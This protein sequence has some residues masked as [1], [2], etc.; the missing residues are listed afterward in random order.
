MLLAIDVGNTQTVFGL[1]R[2]EELAE[3]RR[4][5]T[6]AQR[7]GDE[8]SVLLRGLLGGVELSGIC[9]SSTVP[10]LVREYEALAER[11]PARLLVVGPGVRG[12]GPSEGCP[13]PPPAPP[14]PGPA[15]SPP[16]AGPPSGGETPPRRRSR[17]A[18]SAGRLPRPRTPPRARRRDPQPRAPRRAAAARSPRR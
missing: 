3:Q 15:P 1:F 16:P 4:I 2:G 6:E 17:S 13:P 5:A 12:R 14:D 8:L 11:W 9:L 18:G 7:T 10:A